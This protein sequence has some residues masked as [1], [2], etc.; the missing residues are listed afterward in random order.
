M[1]KI[2]F[3]L[4]ITALL[5]GAGT[6]AGC[7]REASEPPVVERDFSESPQWHIEKIKERDLHD[8]GRRSYIHGEPYHV[9]MLI[10]LYPDSVPHLLAALKDNT[11]TS[12]SYFDKLTWRRGGDTVPADAE[13]RVATIGDIADYAL[14]MIYD[15]DVGYRSYLTTQEREAAI[16]RWDDYVHGKTG[17]L[18]EQKEFFERK[19]NGIDSDIAP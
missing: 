10:E 19:W 3:V 11:Q 6:M 8:C 13:M 9:W 16:A 5:V 7:R 1:S 18:K 15:T 12:V 2:A 4:V 14:R 17:K